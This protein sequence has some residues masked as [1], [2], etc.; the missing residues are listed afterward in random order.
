MAIWL[1][2]SGKS[3]TKFDV[4]KAQKLDLFFAIASELD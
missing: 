2:D 1:T 3:V 4:I